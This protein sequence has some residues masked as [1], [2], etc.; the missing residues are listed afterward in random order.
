MPVNHFQTVGIEADVSAAG[1][2]NPDEG[3][4]DLDHMS[5]DEIRIAG[6]AYDY[7]ALAAKIGTEGARKLLDLIMNAT[8]RGDWDVQ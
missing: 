5:V 7:H 6:K 2:F 1:T 3:G 4:Y 8:D